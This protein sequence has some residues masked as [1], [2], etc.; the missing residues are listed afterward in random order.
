M[1]NPTA[2]TLYDSDTNDSLTAEDLGITDEQYEAAVAESVNCG[3]AEGH[4][5]IG[6]R[7]VYAA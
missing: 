4:I 3:Q 7:R 6:E 1:A 2:D 5:R